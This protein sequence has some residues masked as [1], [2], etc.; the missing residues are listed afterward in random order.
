VGNKRLN[1]AQ[2]GLDSNGNPAS[3]ASPVVLSETSPAGPAL[4]SL[5]G[6]LYLAWTGVGNNQLN[7]A[8]LTASGATLSGPHISPQTSQDGPSLC[9]MNGD[10]YLAW[11]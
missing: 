1:I 10:L 2:I 9:T 4:A 3:L 8:S 7:I 11:T 5:N 6:K